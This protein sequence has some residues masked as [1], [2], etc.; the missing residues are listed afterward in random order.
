MS[1]KIL[2]IARRLAGVGALSLAVLL[3]AMVLWAQRGG[4][5]RNMVFPSELD[6]CRAPTDGALS[7][8]AS[9][10]S[11]SAGKGAMVRYRCTFCSEHAP[12]ALFLEEEV[13]ILI[14]DGGP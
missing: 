6:I 4:S 1:T 3:G 12:M 14:A 8:W 13:I 2:Q 5:E 10:P 9:S 11:T 7:F